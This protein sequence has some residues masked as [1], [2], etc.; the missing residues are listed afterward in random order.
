MI[1]VRF[2][3]PEFNICM[4]PIGIANKDLSDLVVDKIF[5][6]H[7]GGNIAINLRISDF[8]SSDEIQ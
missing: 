5:D 8:V 1:T 3:S 4:R 7:L 2:V 6:I